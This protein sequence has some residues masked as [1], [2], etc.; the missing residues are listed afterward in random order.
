MNYSFRLRCFTILF[1]NH[2]G[3]ETNMKKVKYKKP[4]LLRLSSVTQLGGH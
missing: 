3:K 2:D 1:Y 4:K